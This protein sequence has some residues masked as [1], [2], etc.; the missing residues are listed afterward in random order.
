[1][2]DTTCRELG[3]AEA[4]AGFE[5]PGTIALVAGRRDTARTWKHGIAQHLSDRIVVLDR[6]G[7]LADT[8]GGTAPDVF[9]VAADLLHPGD[10]LRLMSELRSRP[11]TRHS[12]ICIVL[13]PEARET[14]AVALDLGASDLI[15]EAFDP[16]EMALRISTMLTRKRQADRLRASVEDGLRLA[17]TDPL[18]GLYNRRY[19]LPYLGRIAERSRTTG[20]SFAVMVLDLD[21]FKAVNDTHGHAAGD[22]VLVEVAE[23]LKT[24]LR[25][26]DLLARIGGEEF[27]VAMPDSTL[28]TA[29]VTAERIRSV[30]EK[31][32]VT[33]PGGSG[34]IA[35]TV[36]IGL[37]M[38]GGDAK[39]QQGIEELV[40]RAD[41]ALL[42]SKADGRNQ[43]KISQYDGWALTGPL[44]LASD[45]AGI[46]VDNPPQTVSL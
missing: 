2:R 44:P 33:L 17:V 8:V 18:T 41:H 3:F 20:R 43:V 5:P 27:L 46:D 25:A 42:G 38:G 29:G 34:E 21:R 6:D 40:N 35:V 9:V 31:D 4:A 39:H 22:A 13:A 36:S 14:A 30:V 11:A 16:Q 26:V 23:R 12:R 15:A 7:V 10:G 45:G 37:A 19:A 28:E 24:N 32:P 1:M